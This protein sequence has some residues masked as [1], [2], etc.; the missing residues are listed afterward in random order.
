MFVQRIFKMTLIKSGYIYHV[1]ILVWAESDEGWVN[2]I[3]KAFLCFSAKSQKMRVVQRNIS[4]SSSLE[5]SPDHDIPWKMTEN[6]QQY[7]FGHTVQPIKPDLIFRSINSQHC[8]SSVFA[9]LSTENDP[10]TH[11]L[12]QCKNIYDT[13]FEKGF[14]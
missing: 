6:F 7:W 10:L 4:T 13:S 5:L 3:N 9:L 14:F 8:L 1:Y 12:H 2:F 11:I